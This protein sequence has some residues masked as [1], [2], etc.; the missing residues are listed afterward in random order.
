MSKTTDIWSTFFYQISS[1][2]F[3]MIEYCHVSDK[4]LH[5]PKITKLIR[6]L[7]ICHLLPIG[8][9]ENLFNLLKAFS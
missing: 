4:V 7:K 1:L 6:M 2:S 8:I 9:V 3:K 5:I